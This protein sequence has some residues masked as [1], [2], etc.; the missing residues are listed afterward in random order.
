MPPPQANSELAFAVGGRLRYCGGTT[1]PAA[2][3]YGTGSKQTQGRS[4]R[5][6]SRAGFVVPSHSALRA[7]PAPTVNSL[8]AIQS[9]AVPGEVPPR[10]VRRLPSGGLAVDLENRGRSYL[11]QQCQ[12]AVLG[13]RLDSALRLC[14]CTRGRAAPECSGPPSDAISNAGL[15]QC[16]WRWCCRGQGSSR[17]LAATCVQHLGLCCQRLPYLYCTLHPQASAPTSPGMILASACA[18]PVPHHAGWFYD[19]VNPEQ[20]SFHPLFTS[21]S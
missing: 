7:A 15:H 4:S 19:G 12:S 20:V 14:K 2:P 8:V 13:R 5:N 6:G 17:Q 3:W 18:S 9:A 1:V 21:P 16:W 10:P 11:V